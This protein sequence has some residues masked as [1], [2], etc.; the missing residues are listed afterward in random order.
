[1][2][3]LHRSSADYLVPGAAALNALVSNGVIRTLKIVPHFTGDIMFTMPHNFE[4]PDGFRA[5]AEAPSS[6]SQVTWRARTAPVLTG[7]MGP[8]SAGDPKS[9]SKSKSAKAGGASRAKSASKSRAK[10][11]SK[12]SED[13]KDYGEDYDDGLDA[14]LIEEKLEYVGQ[15]VPGNPQSSKKKKK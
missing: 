6:A 4:L 10:K 8:A 14:V 9:K 11:K 7:S 12:E 3:S 15:G 1:M 13:E 5:Q 2:A